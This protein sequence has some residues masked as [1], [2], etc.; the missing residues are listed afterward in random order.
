MIVPC[1]CSEDFL[2]RYPLDQLS[3]ET[4]DPNLSLTSV[5]DALQ[6]EYVSQLF[7]N[8]DCITPIG[9]TR[10]YLYGNIQNGT[11]DPFYASLLSVWRKLYQ[12][13]FR[14]NDFLE[15][16]VEY[17]ME[18]ARKNRFIAEV[19]FLRAFYYSKLTDYWGD[20]PLILK[21]LTID[22]SRTITRNPKSEVIS[23]ILIDLDFAVTNLPELPE[24]AGQ[25]TKGAALALKARVNLY[26][27]NWQETVNAAQAVMDLDI[28]DLY[29]TG[30]SSD[31][32]MI[33]NWQN[34]NNLEVIFD[35]Q[36]SA[37]DLGEGNRFES[38]LMNKNSI[39]N[40]YVWCNPTQYILDSYETRDGNP[41]DT[42]DPDNYSQYNNR[43]YR[44]DATIIRHGAIFNEKVWNPGFPGYT[45]SQSGYVLRK[46][47]METEDQAAV[48]RFD[49][50]NNLIVIRY[51][52]ILLMYA[53]AKNELSGPDQTVYDAINPI[54]ERAGI[55]PLTAGL[56]QSEMR[57]KIWHERMIE[58]AF[59]GLY[60]SDI[61]R[62]E[63][64]E[65]Y[66]ANN[67]PLK[68][69]GSL[70]QTRIFDPGKHYLW[71]VPQAEIDNVPTLTQNSG[72]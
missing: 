29:N 41:I 25:A 22:E 32:A 51:A 45:K 7:F 30:D 72:W 34:E 10:S 63:I 50:P 6:N 43:D 57:D 15:R 42:S 3:S 9:F 26:E 13:V 40:G 1:S 58:L 4:F 64:A 8:L 17:D 59:E 28:Y 14:A 18:E 53:E 21:T 37:P 49:A 61:R 66:I 31:Y 69:D 16:I 39:R 24:Q 27:G 19:R 44:L 56:G 62:W 67:P 38:Y 65:D 55:P 35:V 48:K 71:P 68:N 5:Y 12:G 11:H 33:F 36:F 60:Y 52:D 54:R 47:V 70:I 20:V 2:D 46:Y 23:Q